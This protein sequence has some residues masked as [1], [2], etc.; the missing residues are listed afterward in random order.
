MPTRSAAYHEAGHAVIGRMLGIAC[1]Y[2][3]IRPDESQAHTAFVGEPDPLEQV[4]VLMAGHE[5]EVEFGV[6]AWDNGDQDDRREIWAK[7]AEADLDQ[8]CEPRLRRATRVLVRRHRN[9]IERVAV[10][11]L[12]R[13]TLLADEIDALLRH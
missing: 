9:A 10:A 11:L 8:R 12:E 1:V 13:E 4:L 7:L 3:T 5:A 6:I 2:A